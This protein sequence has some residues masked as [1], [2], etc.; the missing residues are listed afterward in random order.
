MKNLKNESEI[1]SEETKAKTVWVIECEYLWNDFFNDFMSTGYR[2]FEE[3]LDELEYAIDL[4]ELTPQDLWGWLSIEDYEEFLTSDTPVKLEHNTIE[5]YLQAYTDELT[6]FVEWSSKLCTHDVEMFGRDEEFKDFFQT[7]VIPTAKYVAETMLRE[8]WDAE[9][10][11]VVDPPVDELEVIRK[12]I[13]SSQIFK[14]MHDDIQE[15]LSL[16]A[17]K[18]DALD[19]IALME[20]D[21]LSVK[22]YESSNVQVSRMACYLYLY[23]GYR[24]RF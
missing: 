2:H 19:E 12:H 17:T 4:A 11:S 9:Y 18:Y 5:K 22:I 20:A 21:D 14:N 16:G 10:P 24:A 8:K 13:G 1:A 6:N 3:G 7:G 15:L 23:E